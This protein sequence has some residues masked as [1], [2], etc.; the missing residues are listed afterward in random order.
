MRQSKTAENRLTGVDKGTQKMSHFTNGHAIHVFNTKLTY[1]VTRQI[2]HIICTC[3]QHTNI[4]AWHTA[5]RDHLHNDMTSTHTD[6]LCSAVN[7][8]MKLRSTTSAHMCIMNKSLFQNCQICFYL[9]TQ[10]LITTFT[11]LHRRL[12]HQVK[13]YK[14]TKQMKYKM[15]MEQAKS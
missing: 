14:I 5:L 1:F 9:H 10:H 11:S 3:H 7:K 6:T 15:Q 12:L 8:I 2:Q 4:L 13:T